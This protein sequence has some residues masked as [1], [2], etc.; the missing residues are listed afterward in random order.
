ME[1]KFNLLQSLKNLENDLYVCRTVTNN[2][3]GSLAVTVR[4][5]QSIKEG[6]LR[7]SESELNF[8]KKI[9]VRIRPGD[10][11]GEENVKTNFSSS[12][13]LFFSQSNQSIQELYN[14]SRINIFE[15]LSMGVT[16]C[17]ALNRPFLVL[18][19]N[20]YI[21]LRCSRL[22][23]LFNELKNLNIVHD[24]IETLN[25]MLTNDYVDRFYSSEFQ[26]EITRISETYFPVKENYLK[27]L[28]DLLKAK[29]D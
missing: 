6:R 12:N 28:I 27:D 13:N 1:N 23:H 4:D 29:N 16:E 19:Y 21:D 22:K 9:V 7:L 15:G 11:F 24:N 18:N 8:E 2:Q 14:G 20:S 26:K 3:G 5:S 17:L 10:S 25:S